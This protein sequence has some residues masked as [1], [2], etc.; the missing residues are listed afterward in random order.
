MKMLNKFIPSAVVVLMVGAYM[1]SGRSGQNDVKRD[2]YLFNTMEQGM[3]RGL[4]VSRLGKP[5]RVQAC[6]DGLWWGKER[7]LGKNDGSCVVE[8]RYERKSLVFGVGY[9]KDGE[10]ISKYEY[11]SE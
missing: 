3:N 8:E 9:N 11:V 4:V 1:A 7:Y 10:V 5:S 6:G 2:A